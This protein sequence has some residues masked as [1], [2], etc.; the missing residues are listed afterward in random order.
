M[1]HASKS[2]SANRVIVVG[3]HCVAE[4]LAQTDTV[5]SDTE[6]LLCNWRG[7]QCWKYILNELDHSSTALED[8]NSMWHTGCRLIPVAMISMVISIE[9]KRPGSPQQY[10]TSL[11]EK[12]HAFGKPS[13]G[14]FL[15]FW[16][17]GVHASGMLTCITC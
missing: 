1:L 16:S 10:G 17:S 12:P 14:G 9:W 15:V 3:A 7:V 2:A 13:G 8:Y 11:L 5:V 6:F 4:K